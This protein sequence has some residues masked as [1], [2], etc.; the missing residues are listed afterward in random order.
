MTRLTPECDDDGAAE[1]LG[2]AGSED[3]VSVRCQGAV[4][5]SSQPILWGFPISNHHL[6]AALLTFYAI[7]VPRF[8]APSGLQSKQWVKQ[9]TLLQTSKCFLLWWM[10]C[11][12]GIQS[13]FYDKK[14]A[15]VPGVVGYCPILFR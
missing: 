9:E 15:V 4:H 14:L 6:F 5:I 3:Y 8:R 12:Q 11:K 7:L 2:Q 1:A 10:H 13:C